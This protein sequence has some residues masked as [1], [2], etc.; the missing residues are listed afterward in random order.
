M[1]LERKGGRVRK[2]ISVFIGE[3]LVAEVKG[4]ESQSERSSYTVEYSII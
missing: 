1:A 3:L 2:G 4:E